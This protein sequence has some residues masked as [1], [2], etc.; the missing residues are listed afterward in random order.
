MSLVHR[1]PFSSFL[2]FRP[3]DGGSEDNDDDD[4]EETDESLARRLGFRPIDNETLR[5]INR[6]RSLTKSSIHL[7][8]EILKIF[9]I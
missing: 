8:D 3:D 1:C 9:N 6:I 5:V 7:I 2:P 4:D